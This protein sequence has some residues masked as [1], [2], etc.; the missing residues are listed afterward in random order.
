MCVDPAVR[1]GLVAAT[2]LKNVFERAAYGCRLYCCWC[3][4]DLVA[5]NRFWEAM[6]FVP[7]AF[8]AGSR[9]KDRVHIFWQKRIRLDD[10]STPW[11]F[12]A[13]TGGGAL[14]EDRVVLPIPPG[15]K[16]WEEMPRLLP[17]SES[18]LATKRLPG[19]RPAKR[20]K[21]VVAENTHAEGLG[22]LRF[23]GAASAKSPEKKVKRERAMVSP[24][25]AMK[26]R[27]L[28]D[29][30]LEAAVAGRLELAASVGKYEVGRALDTA[31]V[32]LLAA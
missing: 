23:G 10:N 19:E 16:W 24:E 7:L 11:W 27:E 14:R 13:C 1:R 18:E 3:A 17:Q 25:Q 22:G 12:P 30:F 32:P 26:A 21:A 20:E 31:S 8:R 4:Q 2:L 5:A 15:V 9:K 28:R 29:R 6:G